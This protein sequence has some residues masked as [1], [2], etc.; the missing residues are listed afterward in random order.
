MYVLFRS[1]SHNSLTGTIPRSI[2]QLKKLKILKLEYNQLTGEIPQ[3]LGELENL[4]AVNISYNRLQGRLPS[5]GIFQSLEPSS[6]E[7]NLGI[8]SPLIKGPCKMNVPKP[9]VLNPFAFGNQNGRQR[10]DDTPERFKH[11]RFLSASAIIAILAAVVISIGVLVI[12][13]LN[14]SAR[15]SLY[16][17][18]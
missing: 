6:L 11:H 14:I 13:L 15:R 3:E 16:G 8:C 10:S 5:E 7:G 18:F 4:L 2:S 1:M 17:I 12:S 9:L